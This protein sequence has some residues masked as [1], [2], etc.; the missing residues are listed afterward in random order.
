MFRQICGYICFVPVLVV[1]IFAIKQTHL[2]ELID[3][4]IGVIIG[5]I[6]LVGLFLL[7]WL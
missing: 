3:L 1:I 6:T 4:V 2:Q 7:G 5:C